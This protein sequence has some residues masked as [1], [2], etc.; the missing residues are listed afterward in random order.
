MSIKDVAKVAN[1]SI[2]TVSH[3]LN[4]SRVVSSDKAQK[5]AKAIA[6]LGYR[7]KT[8]RP[9]PKTSRRVGVKT[10][11]VMLL[12]LTE[13]PPDRL[14]KM[15]VLPEL[16]GGIQDFLF[17]HGMTFI[18]EQCSPLKPVP[19]MLDRRF[20]DGVIVMSIGPEF[21]IDPKVLGK[22]NEIPFVHCLRRQAHI[23]LKADLISYDND[24]IGGMAAKYLLGRGHRRVVY[25]NSINEHTP[26]LIRG[27][28]FAEACHDYGMKV[29]VLET[30]S[31]KDDTSLADY[32]FLAEAFM[33]LKGEPAGAFFC[34]DNC[35]AG[36][37]IA[38]GKLGFNISQ[39][40]MI[41]CN[42]EEQ[43]LDLFVKRPASIDIRIADIGRASA[44]RLLSRIN[45]LNNFKSDEVV[46]EPKIVEG[47]GEGRK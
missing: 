4:G 27:E 20:C 8:R 3:Y 38:L 44:E 29:D 15:P 39:L 28:A 40:D 34:A 24:I 7:V 14:H 32:G 13:F 21:K 17:N 46:L 16:F 30:N 6:K 9:G 10:G 11:A 26:Y 35:M 23:N 18:F 5:I 2:G 42:N 25:F 1:V 45:G 41:G 43:F 12:A 47:E 33:R 19:E 36:V 22:L 37:G 31:G